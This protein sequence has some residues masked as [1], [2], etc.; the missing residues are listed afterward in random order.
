MATPGTLSPTVRLIIGLICI[1]GGAMP[2]LAAFDVGPLGSSAINGPLWLGFLAG[3]V[4]MAGGIAVILGERLRNSALSYGIVALI[5]GAFA[6][7]ANWIAFGPGPRACAIAFAGLLFESGSWGNEIACRAGFGIGAALLDGFVLWMIAGALRNISGP[8]P[9]PNAI[10]KLG[11]AVLLLAL[12]PIILPMLLF[13]IGRIFIEGFATWRA[14]GRWP[15][16]E[17]FIQRMKAK[18]ATKP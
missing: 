8:G 16:N 11:A 14:T 4:F 15:G 12:A 3:A 6:A 7:I 1:A 5:V 9:V 10:E 18:R 17:A 13:P 2:M